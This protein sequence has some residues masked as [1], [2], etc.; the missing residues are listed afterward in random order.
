MILACLPS[1]RA[2]LI[3]MQSSPKMDYQSEDL[4]LRIA[5]NI[6]NFKTPMTNPFPELVQCM[7]ILD[8]IRESDSW[9]NAKRATKLLEKCVY[10][11]NYLAFAVAC[12]MAIYIVDSCRAVLILLQTPHKMDIQGE[13]LTL[14]IAGR[15][16]NGKTP[17]TDQFGDLF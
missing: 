7:Q 12:A 2:V 14:R 8:T 4:A 15:L 1:C 13:T 16:L 17:M 11:I 10:S 5:R 6:I 3:L 9:L